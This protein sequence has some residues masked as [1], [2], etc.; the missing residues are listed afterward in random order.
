MEMAVA[1]SY[2]VLGLYPPIV[3]AFQ[4]LRPR[5]GE[6]KKRPG[7]PGLLGD[8]TTGAPS[9]WGASS[10]HRRLAYGLRRYRRLELREYSNPASATTVSPQPPVGARS[11]MSRL[12]PR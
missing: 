4:R 8:G 6:D 9:V 5:D 2:G 10:R 11:T 1:R 12:F 3:R 7:H